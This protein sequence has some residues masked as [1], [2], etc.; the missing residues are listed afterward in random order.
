M[1]YIGGAAQFV[2]NMVQN[3]NTLKYGICPFQFDVVIAVGE[4][5]DKDVHVDITADTGTV[6]ED[7]DDDEEGD[8]EMKDG[9][10]MYRDYV[11]DIEGVL[12]G[13]DMLEN[14]QGLMF[15]TNVEVLG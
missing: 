9:T 14:P 7:D 8:V 13:D 5:V 15:V 10:E 12:G 3:S 2:C 4:P 11:G 6:E 1:Q